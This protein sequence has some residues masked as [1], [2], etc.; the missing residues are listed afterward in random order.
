MAETRRRRSIKPCRSAPGRNSD[1]PEDVTEP[2]HSPDASTIPKGRR[3]PRMA[4]LAAGC[5][6]GF[7]MATALL[8]AETSEPI[9]PLPTPQALNAE[10]VRLG[11]VLFEDPRLSADGSM[12]C[13][14]CH[15]LDRGGADGERYSTGFGGRPLT[16]NTPTIF[17]S[18]FNYLRN[19]GGNVEELE[20]LIERVLQNPTIMNER[21][22]RVIAKLSADNAFARQ[23]A[24]A[25]PGGLTG[26]NLTSALATYIRSLTTPNSRFDLY[27]QGDSEA[28]TADEVEGYALFRRYGCV[29]C[30]Q[31]RNI[32]AN[33]R[34]ALGIVGPRGA[35][36]AERGDL[37]DA[38]LGRFQV[39][40]DEADRFV[41][42]VPSLRNVALTAPYLHDGSAATL[43]D[44]VS[45][46]FTYQ[47]GRTAEERDLRL[48]IQ[49]LGSLTGDI[50]QAA[51]GRAGVT[52]QER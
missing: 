23:F 16:V 37:T 50:P 4:L 48:I 46:M 29:S 45:I 6:F 35:Y 17:N 40:G 1:G 30:H 25:Y 41:F 13:A 14:S 26:S 7:G 8:R 9:V 42:R 27:L 33:V 5:L 10:R 44:A 22:P 36:F 12:A 43:E 52:H 38:D 31:G 32:G 21:W 19:W 18:E 39:T 3:L 15:L 47:L 20:A 11:R 28:L 24:A 51:P 49:F 2:L 34:Q